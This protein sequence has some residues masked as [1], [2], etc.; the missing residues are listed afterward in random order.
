MGL[1]IGSHFVRIGS[2]WWGVYE[3]NQKDVRVQRTSDRSELNLASIDDFLDC[4]KARTNYTQI[5]PKY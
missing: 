3:F 4:K 1:Y 5:V 2:K